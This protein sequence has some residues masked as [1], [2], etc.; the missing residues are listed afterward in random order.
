MIRL[1]Y[2]ESLLGRRT[3]HREWFCPLRNMI[4]LD[5]RLLC[6]TAKICQDCLLKFYFTGVCVFCLLIVDCRSVL[7]INN[8]KPK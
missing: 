6:V 4:L 2:C 3:H 8:V 7:G 1:W 5:I